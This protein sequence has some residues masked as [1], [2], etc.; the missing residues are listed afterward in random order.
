MKKKLIGNLTTVLI[1]ISLILVLISCVGASELQTDGGNV[2]ILNVAIP[3]SDG[4][5]ISAYI[6]KP[7]SASST[8]PAPCVITTHGGL[9]NKEMQDATSIELSRRG[10]VVIACD[11]LNHGHSSASL[12]E[13][14]AALADNQDLLGYDVNFTFEREYGGNGMFDVIQYVYDDLSYIDNTR[15]GI[16]GHSQGA[17]CMWG[18]LAQY[19]RNQRYLNGIEEGASGVAM[20]ESARKY[21]AKITAAFGYAF[22]PDA[23]L[24][25]LMPE[26]VTIGY[27]CAYYDEAGVEQIKYHA[28]QDYFLCDMTVSPDAKNM[29]NLVAP[30]TFT[31][32][33]EV[34]WSTKLPTITLSNWTNEETIE[35]GKYYGSEETGY[36]VLYNPKET[37]PLNH[38]STEST[39]NIISFFTTA[40]NVENT[41]PA[42]DQVWLSKELFNFIG[43]IGFFV[44]VL[45]FGNGLLQLP[46]F[47]NLKQPVPEPLPALCTV[48]DKF[49]FYGSLILLTAFSG[50]SFTKVIGWITLGKIPLPSWLPQLATNWIIVWGILC[51]LVALIL[52]FATWLL[53]G[54]KKGVTPGQWGIKI[55]FTNLW[56][57]LLLA[58][59][60]VVA[61]YQLLNFA[62]FFFQTDFR[63][64]T[65]AV[66]TFE[67]GQALTALKYMPFFF[68]FYF[69]NSLC[70]NGSNRIAGQK[71]W[72]NVLLCVLTNIVGIV[73]LIA[74]HFIHMI[75]VGEITGL[76]W[77]PLWLGPLTCIPMVGILAFAAIAARFFFKKTGNIYLGAFINTILIALIQCAN[78]MS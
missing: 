49:L 14:N 35:L 72:V 66:K 5:V 21:D 40:L 48:R 13:S 28:G 65:F 34:D 17:R 10:F 77:G 75:T 58:V 38:F 18:Y 74:I 11:M 63:L 30:N 6:F 45:A 29:I 62:D 25:E 22:F 67:P 3:I 41:I 53:S 33:K 59:L 26:G 44:G 20:P 37:H 7:E 15:I 68:L 32:D 70:I 78:T 16:M 60:T 1:C 52:F 50:W 64:W 47:A 55:R 12:P 27:N 4:E 9:N 43:L 69:V 8:N 51:A 73:I 46:F 42:D 23:Y 19:G 61:A 31:L 24:L 71:E 57:T 76:W 2:E 39:S 36:R 56:K 54:K